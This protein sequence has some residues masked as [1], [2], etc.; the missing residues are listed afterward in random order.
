MRNGH[1]FFG[2]HCDALDGLAVVQVA[3]GHQGLA[4][5]RR[6]AQKHRPAMAARIVGWQVVNQPGKAEL[7]ALARQHFVRLNESGGARAPA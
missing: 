7:V 6:C 2:A 5:F 3:G 1:E 4:V